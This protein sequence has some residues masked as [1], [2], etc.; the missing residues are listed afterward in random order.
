V[1]PGQDLLVDAHIVHAPLVR[2]IA[3]A[4]YAAGAR[5]VDVV[6]VDSHL[7]RALVELGPDDAL[8]WTPAWV[9]QRLE[10]A[11]ARRS[12]RLAVIGDPDP[13]LMA[14]LDGTRVG[15][16]RP[17]AF[18]AALIRMVNSGQVN[19]CVIAGPNEGW[20]RRVFG[21]P[22]VERLWQVVARAVRLDEP[23]PV[24]AWREHLAR[25]DERAALLNERRFDAVRFRGPGTDLR[26][27]LLPVSR[28]RASGSSATTWG[29]RFVGNMPTEEV[30]T[31]PDARATEGA[32]R[33][34]RPLSVG[35]FTVTDLHLEFVEGRVTRLGATSGED[36]VRALVAADE[37]ACRLGEVALVDGE[38]RV[39][40]L[41]L[42]LHNGLFDEN[43][44]CHIALGSCLETTL[45]GAPGRAA[46][47]LRALGANVSAVH[48]DCMIGGPDVEVDGLH[49]GG[50]AVPLLRGDRWL[51]H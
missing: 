15:R 27:G 8:D 26:V 22:D 51:L 40:Q 49:Q 16:A 4:A 11:T 18:G 20:A 34:T 32:V 14:D 46:G 35:S 3:R 42:V 44:A 45:E 1:A 50:P 41:D 7:T 5:H 38:S 21:S 19:R 47:E 43:A 28:W 17:A 10:E 24:A 39:G 31:T 25:L 37:G 29:R 23:D 6:Y 9:V 30:F 13:G 48:T 33:C 12:A 2:R 36:A